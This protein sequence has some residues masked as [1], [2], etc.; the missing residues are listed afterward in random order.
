M[1]P[2]KLI[3]G[4]IWRFVVL[5]AL[6]IVP[7]PGFNG[8]YGR[9]FC[10]L[11]QLIFARENDRRIVHFEPV[12]EELRHQ[13]DIRIALGNREHLDRNGSGQMVFLELDT[14]GIGWVP[15][16]LLLALVLATPV[17]WRRRAGALCLGLL[18]VH[19]LVIFSVA[20]YIWNNSVDLGLVTVGPFSKQ[21][22][23]G[24][25]ETL[26]TQMGASFAAPVLI[27]ML[28][29]IRPK[30]VAVWREASCDI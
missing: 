15:T 22:I 12:P 16:A 5:Y 2:R 8:A 18:S 9:Y 30:D 6:L 13:L 26:I 11:G 20:I 10:A 1:P 28:F 14:R 17:T 21:I 25:E 7:W 19:A 29:T 4:F 24:L 23:A 3:A 27:W